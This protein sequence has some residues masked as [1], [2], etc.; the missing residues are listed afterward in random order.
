MMGLWSSFY[1]LASKFKKSAG[2]D[3]KIFNITSSLLRILMLVF[4]RGSRLEPSTELNQNLISDPM[5]KWHLWEVVF[6]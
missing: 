4:I 5:F 3:I 1:V 6:E 2:Y